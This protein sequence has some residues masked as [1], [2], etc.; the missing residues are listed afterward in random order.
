MQNQ[1]HKHLTIMNPLNRAYAADQQWPVQMS[2]S[3]HTIIGR[4]KDY[5]QVFFV[6]SCLP[7]RWREMD[8]WGD[9]HRVMWTCL[10]SA[11]GLRP[12][13]C[14]ST[15]CFYG[16]VNPHIWHLEL[17][18]HI[19]IDVSFS[20]EICDPP[21]YEGFS[22]VWQDRLLNIDWFTLTDSNF[23]NNKNNMNNTHV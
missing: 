18:S 23:S 12:F 7:L 5:S 1:L 14:A 4:Q 20:F 2:A 17:V 8:G 3:W 22:A 16:K 15:V 21:L 11:E 6:D 9:V 19:N 13:N 10:S